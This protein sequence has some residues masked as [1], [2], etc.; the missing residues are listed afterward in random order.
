RVI[1]A[2]D[3]RFRTLANRAH[4]A[5]AGFSM[6]GYGAV[7]LAA[8]H[9]DLFAAVGG[10]SGV[11][12]IT[13]PEDPYQ[14]APASNP[15]RGAGSP[16]PRYGCRSPPTSTAAACTPCAGPSATCTSSGR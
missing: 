3:R 11:V 7:A 8:R 2:I 6:G 1:P 4:R 12:H 13:I 5:I 9:P 15:R 14:G 16:G 10:F